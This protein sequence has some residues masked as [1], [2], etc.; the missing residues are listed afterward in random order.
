M[1]MAARRRC[2]RGSG[3]AG[4]RSDPGAGVSRWRG[5]SAGPRWLARG[6]CSAA[7]VAGVTACTSAPVTVPVPTFDAAPPVSSS[8]PP[9]REAGDLLPDSCEDLVGHDE[10]AALFGL[11]VGSVALRTV[12]GAPSPSVGRLER[13]TCTYTVSGPAPSDLQGMRLQMVLGAYRDAVAAHDQHGRNVADQRTGAASAAQAELGAAEATAVEHGAGTVL[14]T[15]FDTVT[16]DLDLARRPTPLPSVGLLTDLARR[17]LARVAP[18]RP[19][20][21]ADVSP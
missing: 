10:F 12:Q 16:L 11:P 15:R 19:D 13:M 6:V 21:P 20:G 18:D 3:R 1:V 14:L 8:A 17:V 7:V 2:G 9:T 5:R 4:Y